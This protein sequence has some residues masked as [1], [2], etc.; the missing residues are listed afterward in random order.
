MSF[1]ILFWVSSPICYSSSFVPCLPLPWQFWRALVRYSDIDVFVLFCKLE[2]KIM[3]TICP[4]YCAKKYPLGLYRASKLNE[5][6]SKSTAYLCLKVLPSEWRKMT[7]DWKSTVLPNICF[8]IYSTFLRIFRNLVI[9]AIELKNS[10]LIWME[11][12]L[13]SFNIKI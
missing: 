11:N 2:N 5:Y 1:R 13:Y 6:D 3:E 8:L 12:E 7:G 4:S 10:V 9:F